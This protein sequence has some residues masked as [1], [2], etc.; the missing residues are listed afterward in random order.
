MKTTPTYT[1][2]EVSKILKASEGRATGAA[3]HFQG[4]SESLHE[5]QAVGRKRD[6]TSMAAIEER[7]VGAE[8]KTKS[9][10]FDGC[11]ANAI[12]FA[13]N[14]KAGQ[15]SLGFL[16][17]D[18]VAYVFVQIDISAG[19]FRCVNMSIDSTTAAPSGAAFVV[20]PSGVTLTGFLVPIMGIAGGIA[21][22]LMKTEGKELH[23]RT[24]FPLTDKPSRSNCEISYKGSNIKAKQDLPT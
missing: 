7:I 1:E 3:D 11:Q 12:A 13:L 16:C 18:T 24:A 17:M 20:A 15:T 22:K 9:G 4:H 14:S 6:H 19:A 23:I 10:A 5:L 8:K 2:E 21:M